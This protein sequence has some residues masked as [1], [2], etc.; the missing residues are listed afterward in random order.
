MDKNEDEIV[1]THAHVVTAEDVEPVYNHV[2]HAQALRLME[3]ARLAYLEAIGIPNEALIAR[4]LFIVIAEISVVYKRELF[5]GPIVV[6]CE[7]PRIEGKSMLLHQRIVNERG[8]VCVE[9]SYD[10]RFLS[11]ETKRSVLPPSDFAPRFLDGGASR[12]NKCLD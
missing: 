11:G 2:N 5:A 12:W 9:A 8:K 3:L 4:G 10:L 1:F 7:S 6:T